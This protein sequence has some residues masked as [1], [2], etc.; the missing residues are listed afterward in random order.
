MWGRDLA[1]SCVSKD[2]QKVREAKPD[3]IV[4]VRHRELHEEEEQE[5]GRDSN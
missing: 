2:T 4:H 3:V 5:V 1:K